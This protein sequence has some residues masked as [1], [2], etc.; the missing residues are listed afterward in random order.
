MSF[1][2]SV[3]TMFTGGVAWSAGYVAPGVLQHYLKTPT[4]RQSRST[5]QDSVPLPSYLP[6]LPGALGDLLHFLVERGGPVT[7]H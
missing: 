1:D 6:L 5:H 7:L 2:V 3:L 4:R